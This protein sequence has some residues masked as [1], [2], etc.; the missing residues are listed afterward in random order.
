[1][2]GTVSG[3]TE[4]GGGDAMKTFLKKHKAARV[5]AV[6]AILSIWVEPLD[7][8]ILDSLNEPSLLYVIVTLIS[9][10]YAYSF[11]SRRSVVSDNFKLLPVAW[12]YCLNCGL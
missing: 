3:L 2:Q 9:F 12:K 11:A 6:L 10:V 5:L 8:I 7:F 1:M 4:T